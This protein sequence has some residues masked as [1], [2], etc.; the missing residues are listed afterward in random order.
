MSSTAAII[1]ML[2]KQIF[3]AL[4]NLALPGSSLETLSAENIDSGAFNFVISS[5]LRC[6]LFAGVVAYLWTTT[7]I[8]REW[9]ILILIL[10]LPHV[11]L[12]R[13]KIFLAVV[14]ICNKASA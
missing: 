5:V 8:I 7:I 6:E 13:L 14:V 4:R 11:G 1:K 3:C 10:V 12:N 2:T 9:L